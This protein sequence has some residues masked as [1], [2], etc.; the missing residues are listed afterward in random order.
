MAQT[1]GASRFQQIRQRLEAFDPG[2]GWRLW[3]YYFLFNFTF[4]WFL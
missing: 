4:F 2:E 1:F 3:L